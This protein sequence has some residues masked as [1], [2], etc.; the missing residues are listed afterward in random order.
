MIKGSFKEAAFRVLSE[1]DEPL[2]AD[3]ITEIALVEGLLSTEGKTPAATMAA[4]LYTDIKKKQSKFKKVGRGKFT[5]A[6]QVASSSSPLI[7]IEKQNTLV[8]DS[9]HKKLMEMDPYQ[10]EFLVADLLKAIGYENVEVTKQ[11]GD[12]G[13]DVS[14]HLTLDGVTNVK[15]VIQ[16]KRYKTGNNIPGSVVTQ[17]RGSAEVDQRGLIITTSKFTKDAKQEAQAPNKMPVSLINGE[18]LVSLLIS[19]GIGVK[20]EMV[21]IH[22][23]DTEYF[24]NSDFDDQSVL[25]SSKT[26]GLWPLPGGINSYVDTLLLFLEAVVGG[27]NTKEK[28]VHWFMQTFEKVNSEK[29]ATAYVFVPRNLGFISIVQGGVK[30]TPAGEQALNS[31]N[32]KFMYDTVAQNIFAIEEIVAFIKESKNVLTE[33]EI[34]EYL[35]DNFDVT[36]ESLAQ[37][38]FRL[39]WLV[40]LGVVDREE[41]KYRLSRTAR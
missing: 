39:M 27:V 23:I 18:K 19:K 11:S 8:K 1:T 10:F 24:D 12:K 3:E 40:N 4:Q 14:A 32:L 22:S 16:V 41:G 25:S 7:L 33:Q 20:K 13:I 5:L 37:V 29:A 26:R 17:L 15:T 2:R 30:L 21:T 35:K 6:R 38:S 31:K 36:W 28:A 9:L 34:L